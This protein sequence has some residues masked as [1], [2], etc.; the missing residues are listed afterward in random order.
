MK[1]YYVSGV[2]K[3][4]DVGLSVNAENIHHAT[5]VFVSQLRHELKGI[6]FDDIKI[7]EIEEIE[8]KDDK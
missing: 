2:Y 6:N 1:N 7:E 3:G 8:V 5:L 4:I